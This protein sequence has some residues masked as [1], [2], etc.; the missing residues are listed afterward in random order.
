MING[1]PAEFV[2][3]VYSGQEIFFLF[4]GKKYMYQGF[5]EDGVCHMEIQQH[6][7]WTTDNVWEVKGTSMQIC[8]EKFL[9]A[10]IF[11]GRTFWE[12]EDKIEWLDE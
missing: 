1:N 4:D 10:R 6:I 7:P 11:N 8:M 2:D 12:V 3:T 9:E 5:V